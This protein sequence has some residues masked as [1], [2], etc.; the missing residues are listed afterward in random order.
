MGA[1][2]GPSPIAQREAKARGFDQVLWLSGM[3]CDV[4][5][6]RGSISF[7]IWRIRRGELQ[8]VTAPLDDKIIE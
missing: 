2:Y 3:S 7:L 6:A 4:T 5:E 1:N 8:L